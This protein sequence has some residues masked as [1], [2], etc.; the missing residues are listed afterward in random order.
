MFEVDSRVDYQ[1]L[2]FSV[3]VYTSNDHHIVVPL[4]ID[5]TIVAIILC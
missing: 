1:M 3:M 2:H 5:A 4:K